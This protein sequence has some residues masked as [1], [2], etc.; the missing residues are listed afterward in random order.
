M[1]GPGP[2]KAWDTKGLEAGHD[3]ILLKLKDYDIGGSKNGGVGYGFLGKE[4][5]EVVNVKNKPEAKWINVRGGPSY[6][7]SGSGVIVGVNPNLAAAGVCGGG[8]GGDQNKESSNSHSYNA[9]N[10]VSLG[11]I[12]YFYCAECFTFTVLM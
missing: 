6:C 2:E 11:V 1:C 10:E 5:P 3:N 9:S 4:D 8:R 12:I 7:V